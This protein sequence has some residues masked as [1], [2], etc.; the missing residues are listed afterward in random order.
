MNLKCQHGGKGR[1]G[2]VSLALKKDRIGWGGGGVG[3]SPGPSLRAQTGGFKLRGRRNILFF[4][5]DHWRRPA[6][7]CFGGPVGPG[8]HMATTVLA[9]HLDPRREPEAGQPSPWQ[10]QAPKDRQ[11][12]SW[13][14][15]HC[16]WFWGRLG[17][18]CVLEIGLEPGS[19]SPPNL[20][21]LLIKTSFPC[22]P[23][24]VFGICLWMAV[25]S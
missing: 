14:S 2:P 17:F 3:G 8:S 4:F 7:Q 1:C 18:A 22:P 19:S 23:T 11:G 6:G 10:P 21:N 9:P 5:W 25:G 12:S 20:C 24:F 13:N 16:F 15:G